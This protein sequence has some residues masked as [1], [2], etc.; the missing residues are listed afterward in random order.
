MYEQKTDGPSITTTVV[1]DSLAVYW[2][3][4]MKFSCSYLI[5]ISLVVVNLFY[6]HRERERQKDKENLTGSPDV[7]NTP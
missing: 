3:I 6:V 4:L 7:V 5:N 1:T 2:Y